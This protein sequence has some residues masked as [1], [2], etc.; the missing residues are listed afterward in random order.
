MIAA[1]FSLLYISYRYIKNKPNGIPFIINLQWLTLLVVYKLNEGEFVPLNKNADYTF[2]LFLLFFTFTYNLTPSTWS[3]NIK[4]PNVIP[5]KLLYILA[6]LSSSLSIIILFS[7][8]NRFS[9]LMS[10]RNLLTPEGSEE[11]LS[12]GIGFSLP[13]TLTGW[14]LARSKNKKRETYLLGIM[15]FLLAILTTSKIFILICLLFSIPLNIKTN[16]IPFKKLLHIALT[17]LIGFTLLHIALGKFVESDDGL[18]DSMYRTF[19]SYLLSGVAG[20]S[21]YINNEAQFPSNAV[22]KSI[23]DFIPSLINVPESNILPWIQIGDWY[24]NV[25]T[26]LT[27]W[28][29][30]FSY[31]GMI[32]Y[33][34]LLGVISK[35]IFS[36]KGVSIIPIQRLFIFGLLIIS[37]QDSF[38]ASIKLWI[39]FSICSIMLALSKPERNKIKPQQQ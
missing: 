38:L 11:R 2:F 22:W 33:V 25:Y 7:D 30:G 14:I 18:F 29:D 12:I 17:S 35:I 10:L 6:F 36:T 1:A 26:G 24:G 28:I 39:G 32:I 5:E 15:S 9:D 4:F 34:S 23:G 21:L 20:F 19:I 27:Y 13:L 3:P 8:G 16:N 31:I 37:H